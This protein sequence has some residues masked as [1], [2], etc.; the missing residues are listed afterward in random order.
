MPTRH[1]LLAVAVAFV[2]GINFVLIDVALGSFPPL[3]FAALRFTLVA[4]PAVLLV[5]RPRVPLRWVI[6]VGTFMSAGQFALLFVAIHRGVPPG[7]ASVILQPRPCSRS[8]SRSCSS[9]NVR[10]A[11]SSRVRRSRSAGWS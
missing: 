2:W 1:V 8:R 5:P 11:R 7:L 9:A 10:A 3:L 4:F 6:G